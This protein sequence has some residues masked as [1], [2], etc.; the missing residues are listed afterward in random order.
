MSGGSGSSE[1]IVSKQQIKEYIFSSFLW[2]FLSEHES[3]VK[4]L[5]NLTFGSNLM[6]PEIIEI[7]E[8]WSTTVA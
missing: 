3:W 1:R 2:F 7:G 4:N 6:C 5:W 8:F